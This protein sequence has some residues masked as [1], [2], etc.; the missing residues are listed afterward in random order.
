MKSTDKV[1]DPAQRA[2][3]GN[4][5]SVITILGNIILSI[6]KLLGGFLGKSTA[7]IADAVHSLSDVLSTIVVMVS[8]YIAKKPEDK[9]HPYGHEKIEPIAAKLLAIILIITA[10]GIGYEGLKTFV[11]G[12]RG[13]VEIEVPSSMALWAAVI[14]IIIKEWMYQYTIRGARKIESSALQ[15]DAWHHRSDCFSSIAALIGIFAARHGYPLMDSIAGIFVAIFIVKIGVEIY[16]KSARELLDEAADEETLNQMNMIA[17]TTEGVMNVS[18][19]KTRMVG[20][21]VHAE[22]EICVDRDL[23]IEKAHEISHEVE[24]NLKGEMNNIKDVFIHVNPC[25]HMTEDGNKEMTCDHCRKQKDRFIEG[26]VKMKQ[27]IKE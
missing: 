24:D 17:R 15:A 3:I 8:L 13:V 27:C 14:S 2:R 22:I 20:N 21:R 10:L 23:N 9:E 5:I 16:I 12:F 19:I 26:V 25:R 4:Q 6:L 11:Q 1:T 7:M 18:E